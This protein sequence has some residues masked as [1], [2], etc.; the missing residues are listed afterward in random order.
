M[1]ILISINI[2]TSINQQYS[3]DHIKLLIIN[4]M[5]DSDTNIPIDVMHI[6]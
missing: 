3:S 5:H 6:S 4:V 2:N 1:I